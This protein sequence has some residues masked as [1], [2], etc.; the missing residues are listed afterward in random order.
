MKKILILFSHPKFESSRANTALVYPIKDK[1]GVTFH[2]LYEHYPDFHID[3]PAE[4]ELLKQ[5]D[6]IIWHHPLYWFS[7]PPLM[8][9]WMD[10]VLEYNWAYGPKGNALESKICL[11]VITAGGSRD[12]YCS[13]GTNTY[14]VNEFLRPFEQTV[15]LCRMAFLPPYAVMGTYRLKNEE[16]LQHGRQYMA[17]IDLLQG[18]VAIDDLKGYAF[19][20]D[21]PQLKMD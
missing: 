10:M 6:V 11:N 19:L 16:L 9:Q 4:K 21:I 3:V 7:C 17:L 12:L 15:K 5:H 18:N 1:A 20:N 2:D 8:K 13:A 14:S